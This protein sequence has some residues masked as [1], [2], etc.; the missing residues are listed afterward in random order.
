MPGRKKRVFTR[1]LFDIE[2]FQAVCGHMD[3]ETFA[4]HMRMLMFAWSNGGFIHDRLQVLSYVAR[5]HPQTWTKRVR[6]EML[7]YWRVQGKK[8][9]CDHLDEMLES[10]TA[11]RRARRDP[12]ERQIEKA[13]QEALPKPAE[14]KQIEAAPPPPSSA[15]PPSPPAEAPT[16]RERILEAAGADPVSGLVGPNGRRL[17][18][19]A[20]MQEVAEWQA[21]GLTEDEI[22]AVVTRV[23]QRGRQPHSIR[24]F[25][26]AMREAAQAKKA[27]TPVQ[28]GATIHYLPTEAEREAQA[29][30]DIASVDQDSKARARRKAEKARTDAQIYRERRQSLQEAAARGDMT[31]AEILRLVGGT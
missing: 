30:A 27:G 8:W 28:P 31:A 25:S 2:E 13:P 10:A 6:H 12:V 23:M 22:V 20:D 14:P 9:R 15:P 3:N 16:L 29:R 26:G 1:M 17:G 5:V 24:Y 7:K 11:S 19:P 4:I 18:T 21:A